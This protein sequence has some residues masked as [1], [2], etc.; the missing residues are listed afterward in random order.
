[1]LRKIRIPLAVATFL[2]LTWLF[3]DATGTAHHHVGWLAKLQLLPAVLAMNVAVIAGLVLLTLLFGR[4][5]CSVICPLGVLQD[6]IA[7]LHPRGK[8]KAGRYTFSPERRWLR[9][10]VLAL[11]VVALVAGVGSVV[12]LLAPY[13]SFGRMASN[14][15]KPVWLCANNWLAGISEARGNYDF[16]VVDIWVRSWPTF[17]IA[18]AT[19]VVI[20]ILAWRGGRTYCNTICPVGTVLGYLSRFSL[21]RVTF[22]ADKC[23]SC[24]KCARACKASC[25][26]FKSMRVDYTRCVACGDCLDQCSFGALA[27]RPA[28]KPAGKPAFRPA[29]KAAG[30]AA[31]ARPAGKAAGT[32]AAGTAA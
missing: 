28:G 15:L 30:T 32:A 17:V 19:F 25:I 26:D 1:M 24:S 12:A 14:L 16:Y 2:A 5:Y 3:I 20:A 10:G 4:I 31:A 23:R 22:D 21:L 9:L 7:R 27:F 6:I 13:S 18:A 29:G 8:H 11:F